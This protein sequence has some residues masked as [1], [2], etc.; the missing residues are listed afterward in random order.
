MDGAAD[1]LM[2][3]MEEVEVETWAVPFN[4]WLMVDWEEVKAEV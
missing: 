2:V 4:V 3:E 1:E